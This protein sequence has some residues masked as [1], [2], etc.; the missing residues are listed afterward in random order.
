LSQVYGFIE[1]SG[2][3]IE[4]SSRPDAGTRVDIF[5][6]KADDRSGPVVSSGKPNTRISSIPRA[7]R[8][9][10]ILAVEDDD[11]VRVMT[12]GSLREL[13]YHVLEAVDASAALEILQSD[14]PIDLLFTDLGLPGQINGKML[15]DRAKILRPGMRTLITTA[16]AGEALLRE[17][18]IDPSI[19]LL[20]KPFSF[21][22]LADRI[23]GLLELGESPPGRI[24]VVEDEF[25]VLLLIEEILTRWG[26]AVDAA[27]SYKAAAEKSAG[28]IDDLMGAIVDLGLPDRPGD[29]LVAELRA[30]YRNLPIVLATGHASQD[31]L[32]RLALAGPV[33]VITKPFTEKQLHDALAQAG[34][35]M[36]RLK[37]EQH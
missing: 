36:P 21:A 5:L 6:P 16:Y 18:R 2:G 14:G 25:L 33:G 1:Q 29:E 11:D 34:V 31:V 13:G 10:T 23:R 35:R 22:A 3:R 9:E 20:G 17:G 8:G 32:N 28:G 15:A 30:C 12:V 24:L 37:S 19:E 27:G 4:L 7:R 26:F